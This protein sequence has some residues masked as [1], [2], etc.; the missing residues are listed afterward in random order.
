M[1]KLN[2]IL[3]FLF[4]TSCA[5][6]NAKAKWYRKDVAMNKWVFRY[7]SLDKDGQKYAGKGFCRISQLCIKKFLR[8]EKCKPDPMFCEFGDIDC[9]K[10]YNY[11]EIKRGF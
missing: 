10:K 11:P 4:L 8:K 7:C 5:S 6:L 3:A 1:K 2:I 9:L